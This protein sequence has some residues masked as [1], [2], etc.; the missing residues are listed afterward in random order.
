MGNAMR[1]ETRLSSSISLII[2]LLAIEELMAGH[3]SLKETA[4][5]MLH[6]FSEGYQLHG[7]VSFITC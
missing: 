3:G 6:D 4:T 1:L 2:L 7:A 5:P